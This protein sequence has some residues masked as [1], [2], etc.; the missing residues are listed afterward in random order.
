MNIWANRFDFNPPHIFIGDVVPPMNIWG[1]RLMGTTHLYSDKY[2]CPPKSVSLSLHTRPPC[3][4]HSCPS[5]FTLARCH[6]LPLAHHRRHY[7]LLATTTA[8]LTCA[9]ARVAVAGSFS[10][11]FFS[12]LINVFRL[13]R[14]VFNI[15]RFSI[16]VVF[17]IFRFSIGVVFRLF[18]LILFS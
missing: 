1:T 13:F 4:L 12:F 15:F 9:H 14:V 5:S 17:S 8:R 7:H 11:V 2:R 6:H 18:R 10:K 16:G 3:D